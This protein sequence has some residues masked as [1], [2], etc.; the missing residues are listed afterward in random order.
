MNSD[1]GQRL[2]QL[3]PALY[4]NRDNGDLSAFF[5]AMGELLNAFEA[6]LEQRL[7]D[8]FPDTPLDGSA[9]C[10]E[11]LIPY[12]A[13]LLDVRLVSPT[14]SGRRA[15]VA[16]AIAWRQGKGTLRVVEDIA[17]QL[18][19]LEIV[20]HEGWQRVARTP[21]LN[22]PRLPATAWGYSQDAPLAWPGLAARHP[23]L[24]AA[25]VDLRCPAGAVAAPPGASGTQTSTVDGATHHWRQASWHGAP[26]WPGSYEDP[27]RR[28]VDFRDSDWR[29]GHYH[30]RKLLLYAAPPAGFFLPGVAGVA[31]N[32]PPGANFLDRIEILEEDG[33]T[34]FRNKRYGQPGYQPVPVSG[35][36]HLGQGLPNDPDFHRWRF[37]GLVLRNTLRLDSGRV[38]LLDCA[39]RR[40]EVASADTVQPVVQAR[41]L[42]VRSLAVPAGLVQLEYA[43]VLS[44]TQAARL[45]CSDC[46]F[47]DRIS[48]AAPPAAPDSG[49]I[50]YSRISADQATGGLSIHH[51]T[52]DVPVMFNQTFAQRS[53]GVLHPACA[54]SISQGAEDGGEMGAYHDRYYSQLPQA[55]TDKL[56]DYLPV[57]LEAVIIPDPR[58]LE[59]PG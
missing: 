44:Q 9:T 47:L 23:G 40:I 2:Y 42:L 59:M 46:I 26:C 3:V 45:Q 50:R 24:P 25:T 33:L 15:E 38:E 17:Q 6:T 53:C 55:V 28:T 22:Q 1:L 29:R 52:R 41:S 31:W 4:R 14:A 10:Q 48:G 5:G 27:S 32:D 56:H 54:A 16:R 39:V 19:G 20:V 21:R 34:I 18:A 35:V 58:L 13:E 57:G 30:P 36:V 8:H 43:T 12:F 37:E 7:A 49:C 11:W 51:S